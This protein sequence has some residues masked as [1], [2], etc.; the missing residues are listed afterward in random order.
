MRRPNNMAIRNTREAQHRKLTMTDIRAA[1][2]RYKNWGRWGAD[3]E[4]GTL[5]FVTAEQVIEAAQLP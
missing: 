5:N 1:A 4:L 3:D 2:E